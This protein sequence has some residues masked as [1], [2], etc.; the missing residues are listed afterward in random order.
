LLAV[1]REQ[2]GVRR[3]DIGK[4]ILQRL[5]NP[6]VQL[7]PLAAQQ[8]VVSGFLHQGMFEGVLGISCGSPLQDQFSAHQLHEGMV[9]LL[10]RHLRDC[11]DQF[12]RERTTKRC[13]DLSYLAR[14]RQT[15]ESCEKGSLQRRRD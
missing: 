8:G 6:G 3:H 1:V 4:L 12:V 11:A 15:I 14:C 5:S 10:L 2:S 7:L 9:D 13:P